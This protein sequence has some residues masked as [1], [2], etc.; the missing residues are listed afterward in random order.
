MIE[1]FR[2]KEWEVM[3]L[4]D[5]IRDKKVKKIRL[6]YASV[7]VVRIATRRK[8]DPYHFDIY[9]KDNN[10]GRTYFIARKVP[11]HELKYYLI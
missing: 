10:T 2:E 5:A 11:C 6:G 1:A 9:Q 7:N 8:N 4:E 3:E